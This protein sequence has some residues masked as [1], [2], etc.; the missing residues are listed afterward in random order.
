M[1][2]SLGIWPGYY[3]VCSLS[4]YI[5]AITLRTHRNHRGNCKGT[6]SCISFPPASKSSIICSTSPSSIIK[7]SG[8]S[9]AFQH[10]QQYSWLNTLSNGTKSFSS[11]YRQ[12]N[13]LF[14]PA[15]ATTQMAA[16]Q[17]FK[18]LGSRSFII[19]TFTLRILSHCNTING[20]PS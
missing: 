9:A 6:C 18:P 12:Q 13:H 11:S 15:T 17:L 1:Y 7:T 10:T 19:I 16:D 4:S 3:E 20:L 8:I 14:Q 5:L 2:N